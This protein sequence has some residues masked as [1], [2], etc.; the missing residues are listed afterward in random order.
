MKKNA[1]GVER[2]LHEQGYPSLPFC[3]DI[4]LKIIRALE[5]WWRHGVWEGPCDWGCMDWRNIQWDSLAMEHWTQ[6]QIKIPRR[7]V[8]RIAIGCQEGPGGD[9]GQDK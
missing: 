4:C 1:I 6:C 9:S 5:T 8:I 3:K 2:C 7:G